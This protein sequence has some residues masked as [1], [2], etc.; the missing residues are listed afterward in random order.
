M[1][2]AGVVETVEGNETLSVRVYDFGWLVGLAVSR[3]SED[4]PPVLAPLLPGEA[5]A[6][7]SLLMRAA[8]GGRPASSV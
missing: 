7:A 1:S 3:N 2:L 5:R 4:A 8:G 6:V